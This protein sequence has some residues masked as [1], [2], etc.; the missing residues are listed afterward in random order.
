MLKQRKTLFFRALILIFSGLFVNL[1]VDSN[2]RTDTPADSVEVNE[3]ESLIELVLEVGFDMV[4]AVPE[5]GGTAGDDS[6]ARTTVFDWLLEAGGDDLSA[7]LIVLQSL[8][9]SFYRDIDVR[10]F[11]KEITPPPPRA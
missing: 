1:S 3:I 2:L 11:I 6:T 8:D 7:K 10:E 4:E 9:N 5:S